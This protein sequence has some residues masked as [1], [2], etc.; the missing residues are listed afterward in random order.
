MLNQSFLQPYYDR[1]DCFEDLLARS[2]YMTKYRRGGE[3]WTDTI[4]RVVEGNCSVAQVDGQ[5]QRALFDLFWNMKALPPGRALWTGGISGI[6]SDA[7]YNCWSTTLRTPEDWCW[8]MNQLMLG[9]GVGFSL[10]N[11]NSLP[12]VQAGR[13]NPSLTIQCHS[14]HP[15]IE[16]VRPDETSHG[17][18]F[19][20]PD[21]REGWVEAF[22]RTLLSAFKG[23]SLNVVVDSIRARGEP[24]RTFG[25][26]ASGPGPLV[27]LLRA[28]WAIIRGAVG[29]KLSSVECLDV[30]NHIGLCIKAGNV[31]RSALICIGEPNDQAFRDAKKD[32]AKVQA[33]RHT[34]NNTI[35]F[36]SAEEIS[37]FDW[38]SLVQ[39]NMTYGEPGILNLHRIW[40]DDPTATGINPC[41]TGDTRIATQHG[42]VRIRDL[43]ERK[44]PLQVTTDL[45]VEDGY[46]VNMG[47]AGTENREAVPAYRTSTSEV[48]YKV[49][50]RHGY[51]V[52]ATAKHK[53]V[54]PDGFVLL[55]D[56]QVGDTL[57]LQSAE[58]QW[59]TEGSEALGHV[60]GSL[61]GDGCFSVGDAHLSFWGEQQHLADRFLPWCR[62]LVARHSGT[63]PS[64]SVSRSSKANRSF[65]HSKLLCRALAHYGYTAK[66]TIPEVVW[67]GSRDCARGYLRGFF[68]A[69]GTMNWTPAKQTFSL[70]YCQSNPDLLREVQRLLLNFGVVSQLYKRREAGTRLLPDGKGGNQEYPCKADYELVIVGNNAVQYAEKV[71]FLLDTHA[72]KFSSWVSSWVRGPYRESHTTEIVAIEEAG[73]EETFCTTQASHHTVIANGIV[74]GQCGEIP[75][76]DREA[77]NLSEIYPARMPRAEHFYALA[78]LTRYTVRQKI[79]HLSDTESDLINRHNMRIGVGL[80][81][82]CDFEWDT[83][84]LASLYSIVRGEANQYTAELGLPRPIAVT[85]TKPSGTI[86]LLCS[87]SP[88]IHAPFAP[89]YIR[90]TR[91]AKND[92]MA[93]AMVSAGVPF[94]NCTYDKSGNTWVFSF[95]MKAKKSDLTVQNE[96]I[97]E[98]FERQYQVQRYWADNSVSCTL[99]FDPET[100][101]K[102]LEA[103]LKEYVPY[104]KS[105]SFL[106]KAHGYTQPPYEPITEAEYQ[107]LRA[108]VDMESRLQEGDGGDIQIDECAGGACP[109]R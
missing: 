23:I 1:G 99:S 22:R 5:E 52:K 48:V 51:E 108:Q 101:V 50:T 46:K 39:D 107:R 15:N 61:E 34:S 89:F 66:G 27:D 97:Y 82:I 88:G 26:I 4:R 20:V 47:A 104:F 32:W 18:T 58:G 100:E 29:R 95:P 45:R 77:C 11:I 79:R 67:S 42:M 87:S 71:G 12:V 59:G 19:F 78:L 40:Q 109:I 53:F 93:Y 92:P 105:T 25:G 38:A 72:Q 76:A 16:E 10:L 84:Y 57:L 63:T 37:N 96:G 103:C 70:R 74:T 28:T 69:D 54:T 7:A 41:F 31:R 13:E 2:T 56:L 36:R 35:A 75:L 64:F 60:I 44:L 3:T 49:T 9:G 83:D 81:G 102:E 91:I 55:E 106:P 80:G 65:I 17:V 90:R 14:A 8:G 73:S 85:T 94:E 62:E 24:L 6:P 98:Q 68:A 33:F 30:T 43:A 21:T 86:S